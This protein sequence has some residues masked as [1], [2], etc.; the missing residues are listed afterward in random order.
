MP[1]AIQ[2]QRS[3]GPLRFESLVCRS[4]GLGHGSFA[5]GLL[6]ST[7]SVLDDITRT[8]PI[9]LIQSSSLEQPHV[10]R[11]DLGELLGLADEGHQSPR[12]FVLG[13]ECCCLLRLHVV[14]LNGSIERVEIVDEPPLLVDAVA[15]GDLH[16]LC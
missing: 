16:S 8:K 7:Q 11:H 12:P 15:D 4:P 6:G 1:S 2:C 14:E 10:H 5:L 13:R 3:P 9:L